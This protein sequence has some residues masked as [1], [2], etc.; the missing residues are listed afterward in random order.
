MI[1]SP[2]RRLL[3]RRFQ[4]T[5]CL[6]AVTLQV[7]G[8]ALH[9]PHTANLHP[10]AVAAGSAGVLIPAHEHESH[11]GRHDAASCSQ[12]RLVSQLKSLAPLT[13]VAAVPAVETGW[14]TATPLED[15]TSCSGRDSAA[16]RA[17]PF[18]A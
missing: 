6:L 5:L 3:T 18:L 9:A 13:I 8:P 17:P 11:Q 2:L 10:E 16:P 12:C 4:A 15:L 1:L 14:L 7:A